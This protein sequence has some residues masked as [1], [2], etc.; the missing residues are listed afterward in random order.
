MG[1]TTR[2]SQRA[3]RGWLGAPGA[4]ARLAAVVDAAAERSPD[5]VT[6]YVRVAG[7]PDRAT[8]LLWSDIV[9]DGA[10]VAEVWAHL[11]QG[12]VPDG[13]SARHALL[14]LVIVDGWRRVKACDSPGCAAPFVD[15]TPGA[16]RRRCAAH[17]RR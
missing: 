17:A 2:T 13:A 10:P 9:A 8:A 3:G 15:A 14:L 16:S 11:R 7:N 6:P 4:A 12:V 1:R 5:I